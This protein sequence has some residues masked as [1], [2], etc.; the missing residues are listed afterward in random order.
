MSIENIDALIIKKIEFINLYI[1]NEI[2]INIKFISIEEK[3]LLISEI[4][5]STA[6]I[7]SEINK[8]FLGINHDTKGIINEILCGKEAA[9]KA[10]VENA[11]IINHAAA[12]KASIINHAA[13]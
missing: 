13:V 8:D 3:S 10:L 11:S 9:L 7:I 1:Y 5:K 6:A 4:N 2:N 12:E